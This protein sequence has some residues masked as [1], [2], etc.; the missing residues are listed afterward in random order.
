VRRLL[1][2]LLAL[3]LPTSAPADVY[4]S[5]LDLRLERDFP[6]EAIPLGVPVTARAR[7]HCDEPGVLEGFYYSEQFPVWLFI[8][9][10]AVRLNGRTIACVFETGMPGDVQDGTIPYRWVLDEPGVGMDF[11][12]EQGDL[13]E[14]YYR[15]IA[16]QNGGFAPGADGWFGLYDGGQGVFAVSGYDDATPLLV[17]GDGTPAGTP[18]PGRAL[19]AAWPNPF[20][21][22]TR[23]AFTLAAPANLRL[24]IHDA[25]G[26]RVRRLAEGLFAAGAHERT[27]DGRDE[28]GRALPAG[29]YFA[30]MV[31]GDGWSRTA[32]LVM[33]K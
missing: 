21:P 32:R 19:S 2:I 17:F 9:P 12:L 31:C 7:F 29:V 15:M 1:I 5:G 4:P 16:I 26:R 22:S 10:V 20:N 25:R 27:W 6:T 28:A 3:G 18:A 8:Q 13:L 14:I 23:L 11:V 33:V 30:R 24:D